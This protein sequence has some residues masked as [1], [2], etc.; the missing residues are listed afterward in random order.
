MFVPF[1]VA[2][3]LIRNCFLPVSDVR[4]DYEVKKVLRRSLSLKPAR[5]ATGKP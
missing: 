3:K 1:V 2:S 4:P 5:K